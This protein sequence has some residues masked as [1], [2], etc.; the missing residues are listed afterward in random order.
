MKKNF[1]KGQYL[2]STDKSK[3]DIK[4]IHGYLSNSY[5][6]KNRSLQTSKLALKN[7][8]CFGVYYKNK[9]IGFARVITD[10]ATFAYLADV[11]ILEEHRGKGLSKW[12]MEVILNYKE[13]QNLGRWFLATKDAHK[14]YEKFGFTSL[15]QPE[16]LMEMFRKDL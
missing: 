1:H 14:L 8:I 7:S 11:F 2:I 5:W 6:A 16:K 9:Q 3:L 12:L 10:N 13:L 4:V 15:K